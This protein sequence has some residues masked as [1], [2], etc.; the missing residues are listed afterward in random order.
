MLQKA[1]IGQEKRAAKLFVI[2]LLSVIFIIDVVIKN[3]S[4]DGLGYTLLL[5]YIFLFMLIPIAIVYSKRENP[6][7]VKYMYFF[8][9]IIICFISEVVVFWG[10]LDYRSGNIAEAFFILF[11]PIFINKR[12]YQIVTAGFFIKY[13]LVG[14][15]L[16][17]TVV[18]LPMALTLVFALV[19]FIIL[20]R[21]IGY[22]DAM[23]NSYFKQ[24]GG[25]VKSI[26]STLELKDPYTRGHSERVAEYA[27]ILAESLNI[28]G[29]DDL[30]LIYYACLLHDVGKVHIPDRILTKPSKLTEE[31][32]IIVKQHPIVGANAIKDL[33]GMELCL[34]IVLYH[35]ERWDGKGYPEGLSGMQIPLTARI[36]SIADSFDAMTSHRSYRTAMS[37]DEAYKQIIQGVGTQFDP[38]LVDHFNK[39]FLAWTS[40]LNKKSLADEEVKYVAATNF[41]GR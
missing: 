2:L 9:Y 15:L 32:F 6:R 13:L 29:E 1:L 36:A 30:K 4:D 20:H 12:Y 11:S 19:A 35:H 38:A 7:Y 18:L 14:L 3:I 8:T 31:E 23:N 40:I 22:I 21:F 10:S 34:D 25:V 17:T 26:V 39:A 24:F 41:E 28:Y 33:E 5:P 16:Q 27:V 37:A